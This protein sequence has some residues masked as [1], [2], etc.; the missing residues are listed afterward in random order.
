MIRVCI[1]PGLYKSI[2]IEGLL[3]PSELRNKKGRRWTENNDA[4]ENT[5][6][7]FVYGTITIFFFF[8]FFLI[9]LLEEE[10][11]QI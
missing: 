2:C 6:L 10:K 4:F 9:S 5:Y 8:S 3:R 11:I 7:L 1:N